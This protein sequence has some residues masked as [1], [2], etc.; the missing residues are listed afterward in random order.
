MEEIWKDIPGFEGLYEISRNADIRNKITKKE[1]KKQIDQHGAQRKHLFKDGKRYEYQV[2]RLVAMAFI[3]NPKNKPK[4]RHIDGNK[5]NNNVENIAWA[6]CKEI[7]DATWSRCT[8]KEIVFEGKTFNTE[9]AAA[10]YYGIKPKTFSNRK[11][12]G[13]TME[14][15]LKIKTNALRGQPKMYKYKDKI[16]TMRQLEQITKIK[17]K[18]LQRRLDLGWGICETIET[19]VQIRKKKE[20]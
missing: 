7:S 6:T 2:G 4:I 20:V 5:L 1:L 13:W 15:N 9:S 10:R 18:T 19:P 17:K 14:E 11:H 16:Y 8:D 3:P 12:R